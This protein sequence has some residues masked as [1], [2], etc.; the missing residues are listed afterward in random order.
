MLPFVGVLAGMG[1]ALAIHASGATPREQAMDFAGEL[2]PEIA[3]PGP[4]GQFNPPGW[5]GGIY[6][7]DQ[8]FTGGGS[9]RA[10][11]VD[12]ERQ[13][14]ADLGW[15]ISN[16]E[17]APGAT[18]ITANRED[19]VVLIHLYGPPSTPV[20]EGLIQARYQ[21]RDATGP[22]VAG[23]LVGAVMGSAFAAVVRRK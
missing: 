15:H 21:N 1:V 16:Y 5:Y 10:D 6:T 22:V 4:Q 11:L 7:I 19:L 18:L 17:E 23:G 13:R 9:D 20:V 3:S 8:P 2:V 14:L 12:V